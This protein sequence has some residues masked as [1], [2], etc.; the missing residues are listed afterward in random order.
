MQSLT[1]KLQIKNLYNSLQFCPANRMLVFNRGN[2]CV[3][4]TFLFFIAFGTTETNEQKCNTLST[5]CKIIL[6][7]VL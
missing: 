2:L 7:K 1:K 4:P 5:F 3:D 6:P